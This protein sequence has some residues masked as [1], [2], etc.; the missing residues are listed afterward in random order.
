MVSG[1]KGIG[2]ADGVTGGCSRNWSPQPRGERPCDTGG[3]KSPRPRQSWRGD[4]GCSFNVRCSEMAHTR[5]DAIRRRSR[6]EIMSSSEVTLLFAGVAALHSRASGRAWDLEDQLHTC[7]V[8]LTLS[9]LLAKVLLPVGSVS[10]L[11][12]PRTRPV[13]LQT[14]SISGAVGISSSDSCSHPW[15]PCQDSA[16]SLPMLPWT[17]A[18]R[19]SGLT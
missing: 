15:D 16:L 18:A 2:R 7:P 9:R 14:A 13:S 1:L 5:P 19:C 17:E 11:C 4:S 12:P 3:W 10:F 6:S 8:P